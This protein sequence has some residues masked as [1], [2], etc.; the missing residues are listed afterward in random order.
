VYHFL[1]LMNTL[2]VHPLVPV[3]RSYSMLT[4]MP[5]EHDT[6]SPKD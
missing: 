5:Y 1:P 6:A 4:V 2:A 3:G